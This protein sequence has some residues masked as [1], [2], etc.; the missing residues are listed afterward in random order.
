MT[1]SRRVVLSI[2]M[3]GFAACGGGGGGGTSGRDAGRDTT[4]ATYATGTFTETGSPCVTGNING[5]SN[6]PSQDDPQC[7]LVEH[8]GDGGSPVTFGACVD[9]FV[10]PCWGWSSCDGG[11]GF[12]FL[13]NTGTTSVSGAT[14]SY[15]CTVCPPGS[16]C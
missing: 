3:L 9:N 11:L 8:P 10:P 4:S 12:S 5:F 2:M 16:S 6:N 14:F 15:Q 7:T 1:G 13:L